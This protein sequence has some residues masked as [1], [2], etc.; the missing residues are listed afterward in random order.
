[1]TPQGF[2]DALRQV[3]MLGTADD[4]LT[5][6]SN[7][8]G[9][10]ASRGLIEESEWYHSLTA[11][12]RAMLGRVLKRAAHDTLHGVLAVLDGVRA[13]ENAGK[14]D[15]VLTFVKG[16]EETVLCGPRAPLL[17]DLLDAGDP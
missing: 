13:V 16:G 4:M 14:G 11:S 15:F 8:P 9:R 2:V 12:D 3:V 5:V 17:H 7:P 10:R 1:M 6:L